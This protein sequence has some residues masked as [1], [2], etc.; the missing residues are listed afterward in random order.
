MRPLAA[1]TALFLL[2]LLLLSVFGNEDMETARRWQLRPNEVV[3]EDSEIP[4]GFDGL[5]FTDVDIRDAHAVFFRLSED[6]STG[7]QYAYVP[8]EMRGALRLRINSEEQL[9]IEAGDGEPVLHEEI[10]GFDDRIRQDSGIA[11]ED[12]SF[13]AGADPASALPATFHTGDELPVFTEGV[14]YTFTMQDADG[15]AIDH[16]TVVFLYSENVPSMY[17]ETE[18]GS[19]KAVND[20]R[21]HETSEDATYRIYLTDGTPDAGGKCTIKGRG[22]STWSQKKRPYNL[23][24]EKE[25]TLLGM[26]GCTKYAL[27]ANFWDSTQTRQYY[28]FEAA[29]RLGLAFTPQEQFVNLYLNGR[30]QSLY[31]LSQRIN[32]KGG[33]VNIQDLD[34]KNER[35]NRSTD[36][37]ETAVQV[38]DDDGNEGLACVWPNEPADL[39]GG[40]LI[41]FQ[42]RYSGE[43]YWFETETEHMSFKSPELPS[44]GEYQYIQSYVSE[45]E[46]ALF[47]TDSSSESSVWDYFDMDSWARMY[48]IQDFFVQ[49]DDE[50][51]SFF[52]YKQAGDPL[53]YCG[54]VWDFDLCLGNMNCGDYYRTSAQ[55]LWL[56]DGRKKWLHQMDQYPEFREKVADLYLTELEPLI[57]DLL[58]EEYDQTTDLLE[59]DA[60]LN[61]L[62]WGKKLDYRERTG[63]VR[64]LIET[65]VQ[66]LHDYYTDPDSFCRLLFHF[67]WGDF[68]YYVRKGESMGFLPTYD[69]GEKQS[70]Y[71]RDTNGYISGWQDKA[72]GALLQPDEA[73]YESREFNPVIIP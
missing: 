23:R 71:E 19:M 5:T 27:I 24:L 53:L 72:S 60:L 51:Y 69:Y 16:K 67:A 1:I 21:H 10:P 33:T 2:I 55:T 15:A 65:R 41:E 57:R 36:V 68:S 61:Y 62:R 46:A 7:I 73:I 12:A 6:S 56:R 43:D 8:A 49:S 11:S 59:K 28:S 40:Y 64:D 35:A 17:I 42:N 38:T 31:L 52:F 25:N 45:A 50:F 22:N 30:Y 32:V 66:F 18:S 29:D 4:P 44:V 39:T 3:F 54:P 37:P 20:D 48:L 13:S 9:H 70:S 58:E 26:D 14:P 34:E 63:M 47:G